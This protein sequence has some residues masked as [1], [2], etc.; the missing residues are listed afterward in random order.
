LVEALCYKSKVAGSIHD[1]IIG[2]FSLPNPSSRTMALW[3]T[4]PLIEMSTRNLPAG[5]GRLASKVDLTAISEPIVLNMW[6]RR[7]LTTQW[8]SMACQR[9]SFTFYLFVGLLILDAANDITEINILRAIY[10]T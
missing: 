3:S 7:R 2:F 9:D 8:T 5:K 6:E 10:T 4:Q 1:E